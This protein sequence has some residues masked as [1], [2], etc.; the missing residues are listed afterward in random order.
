MKKKP[1]E[2]LSEKLVI[3]LEENDNKSNVEILTGAIEKYE[4]KTDDILSEMHTG[5]W[6]LQCVYL[7]FLIYTVF[8]LVVQ[9]FITQNKEL[10]DEHGKEHRINTRCL[11]GIR[12]KSQEI[13]QEFERSYN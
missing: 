7:D 9:K 10:C 3:R 6:E 4:I 1:L 13:Q 11:N 12:F 8:N 2:L 5:F